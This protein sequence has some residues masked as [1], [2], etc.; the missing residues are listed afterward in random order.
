MNKKH[1]H[2]NKRRRLLNLLKKMKTES[3]KWTEKKSKKKLKK[4]NK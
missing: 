3:L 1:L 2:K 4:R